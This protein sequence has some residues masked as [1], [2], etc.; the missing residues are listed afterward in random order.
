MS[1]R[2]LLCTA[3]TYY[4]TTSFLVAAEPSPPAKDVAE[5]YAWFDTLELPDV[6]KRPY[7]EV[8]LAVP[9]LPN[10][11]PHDPRDY[12]ERIAGFLLAEDKTSL[13]VWTHDLYRLTIPRNEI[14]VA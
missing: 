3:L 9:R 10:G 5:V 8:R 1:M 4:A 11:E 13:T 2:T 14:V 7:V 6:A 12:R